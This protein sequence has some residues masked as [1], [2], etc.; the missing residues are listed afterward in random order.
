[1]QSVGSVSLDYSPWLGND[2]GRE[3]VVRQM[4][5]LTCRVVLE[6]AVETSAVDEYL[7]GV[8]NSEPISLCTLLHCAGTEAAANNGE[9]GIAVIGIGGEGFRS[10]WGRLV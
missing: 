4:A 5:G 6:K 3:V 2:F 10:F 8:D 1:M 7:V 9:V